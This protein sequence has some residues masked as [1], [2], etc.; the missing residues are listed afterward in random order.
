[1]LQEEFQTLKGSKISISLNIKNVEIGRIA[2]VNTKNMHFYVNKHFLLQ[3]QIICNPT[4]Y[5]SEIPYPNCIHRHLQPRDRPTRI[6]Y[7]R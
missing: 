2:I 7:Q 1:M 3:S 5:Q 4:T 6:P